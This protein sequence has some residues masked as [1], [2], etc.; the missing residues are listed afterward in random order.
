MSRP[1]VLLADAH[2]PL[3]EVFAKLLADEC[4]VVGVVSSGLALLEAAERLR[5]D[6]AV[7]DIEMPLSSGL[8][9]VRRLKQL[10]PDLR[11]V[12]LTMNEDPNV[13]AEAFRAGASGYLLK[14]SAASELQIAVR[15]T[16]HHRSYVT[17]LVT[18]GLVGTRRRPPLDL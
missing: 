13:A 10:H 11:I 14:R 3:L 16:M 5:P 4:D 15:E 7:V 18:E 1:R 12:V 17:P 2:T 6:V 8:V 9:A